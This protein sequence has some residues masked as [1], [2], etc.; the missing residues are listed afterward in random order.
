M[1]THIFIGICLELPPREL[2]SVDCALLY[3]L[4]D[5]VAGAHHE[6]LLEELEKMGFRIISLDEM[7]RG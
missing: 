7:A 1:S 6:P 5:K 3:S 4:S 2:T